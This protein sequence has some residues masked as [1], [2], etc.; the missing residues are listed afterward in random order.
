MPLGL[1]ALDDLF[2]AFEELRGALDGTDAPA[3]EAAG[4]RID[5][6]AAAVRAIGAWRSDEAVKA[7]LAAL[8]PLL[9]SARVRINVL[10][11]QA[12]QRLSILASRGSTQ[13]PLTYGR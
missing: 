11:D 9:E 3:I 7:R 10:T 12:S 6:A 5:K 1:A 2:A 8:V 4:N 13:A